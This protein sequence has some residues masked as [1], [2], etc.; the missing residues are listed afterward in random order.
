MRP[1]LRVCERLSDLPADQWDALVGSG[2]PFLEWGWLASLED[3][4]CVGP[5]TGWLPQ[6]LTVW[7]G[8]ALVAA[9]PLYVKA[10]S[11]G[12]FVFDHGWADAAERAG[13]SY[14]PKLLAGVPFTPV[15][16]TRLLT[17]PTADRQPLA[18]TLGTTL[19]QLCASGRFSSVHVN[20]CAAE[21]VAALRPLGFE[22]RT[23]YQF[24]WMNPGWRTFDDYLAA[25]RS[26]RRV[27]I[28]RERRE[29]DT[30]GIT[31]TAHTGDDLGNELFGPMFRLYRATID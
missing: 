28:K 1:I 25:F 13:L 12:E 2:S 5:G 6:H 23:G 10:H 30:Q 19:T 4:G 16:G 3:A 24:Q 20:F 7:D 11:Q 9:C 18:R 8:D 27:Q 22:L 17:H 14:Y 29:L 26:K 15:T 21:D 31:I